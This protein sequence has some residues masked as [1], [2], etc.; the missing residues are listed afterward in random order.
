MFTPVES[1]LAHLL[2]LLVTVLVRD[3]LPHLIILLPCLVAP[4]L[5]VPSLLVVV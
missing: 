3:F 4:V 1:V 5:L 2:G